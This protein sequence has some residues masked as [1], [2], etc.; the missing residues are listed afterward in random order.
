MKLT[1]IGTGP[2][3]YVASIAAAKLGAKVTVIEESE[4]GGTCLNR[5]CIPTKALAESSAILSKV[6][7][8]EDYGIKINGK[9]TPDIAKIIERK[10]RIINSQIKGIKTLFES[11]GIILKEGRGRIRSPVEVEV[12]L[13]DGSKEVIKTDKIII[14]TGSRPA[15]LPDAP[16]DSKRI[17][18][19]NDALN[20]RDIP[21]SLLIIGAGVIGCEFASIYKE[22]GSEVTIVETLQRALAT[23]D[24]EISGLLEKEFKKKN[25]RLYT[26][27]KIKKIEIKDNKVHAILHDKKKITTDKALI[28]GG[29]EFNSNDIGIEEVGINKGKSGEIMVNEKMETNVPGVYAIG[30]VTGRVLLAHVASAQGIIAARNI[31]GRDEC[32]NYDA[33]PSAIFTSPEIASVGLREYQAED[34]GIKVRTGYFQFRSLGRA[35]IMGEINGFIKIVSEDSTDRILGMHIIGPHASDLIHEGVLAIKK[36]LRTKDIAETIHAHPT[37]SEGLMEAAKDVFHEAIHVPKL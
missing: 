25:I 19:S 32:M 22:L 12:I 23:E 37:L 16:F 34:R 14:A 36:G 35:H 3:G 2:G 31:M 1:V 17:I 28:C 26:N 5:G 21:K 29:R 33:I 10:N 11:W 30:D 4:V 18:S 13:K 20:L 8:L 7:K 15:E 6:R 27:T 9:I 24:I